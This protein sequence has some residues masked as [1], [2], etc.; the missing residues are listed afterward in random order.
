ML[1]SS[2]HF[3]LLPIRPKQKKSVQNKAVSPF[4]SACLLY[5]PTT[6][7]HYDQPF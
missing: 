6:K 5:L 2:L 7:K 3:C 1:K 4:Q